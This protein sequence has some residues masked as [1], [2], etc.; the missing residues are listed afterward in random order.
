MGS[1]EGSPKENY[2]NARLHRDLILAPAGEHGGVFFP[3]SGDPVGSQQMW[4]TGLT[5][6]HTSPCT[7]LGAL[8]CCSAH[9]EEVSLLV[10]QQLRGCTLELD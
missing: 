2:C 1:S 7:T 8:E 3:L 4:G 5:D 9:H 6:V 10:K